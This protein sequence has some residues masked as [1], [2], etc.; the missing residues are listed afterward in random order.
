MLRP[1]AAVPGAGEGSAR[2]LLPVIMTKLLSPEAKEPVAYS[3]WNKL[4][5]VRVPA[6][7]M[8]NNVSQACHQGAIMLATPGTSCV[9]QVEVSE[10][11]RIASSRLYVSPASMQQGKHSSRQVP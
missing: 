9:L 7:M 4:L 2:S 11:Y 6:V 10:W 3:V 8:M 1:E 5:T